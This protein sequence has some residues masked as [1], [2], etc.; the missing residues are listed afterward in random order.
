MRIKTYLF[1]CIFAFLV[2][3][4]PTTSSRVEPTY[5]IINCRIIP[6]TTPVIEKGTIIIR[7]GLIE[8]LGPSDKVTIPDD[9]EIIDTQ[10]LC[11][12][13]GLIDSHTEL[14]VEKPKEQPQRR[15]M[16]PGE[17]EKESGRYPDVQAFNLIKPNKSII[18]NYHQIGVTTVLVTPVKGIFMGQSVLLNLNG[19]EKESMVVKNSVALHV[20]F[21]T[22]RG[23]YPETVMGTMAFLRQSFLDA[24][25]YHMYKSLFAKLGKGLKRQEYNPFL[26]AL[27]PFALE[28]KPIAF[29]C[30]NQEDIKRTLRLAQE[31]KLTFLICGANEAWRVAGLLKEAQIP[32]LISVD[33][34]PPSTSLYINQGEEVK[35]KAEEEIYPANASLLHKAG[36]TFALT[37]YG[38]NKPD[39]FVSNIRQAI[40]SGLPKEEALKALTVYPSQFLG[41]S[42]LLG[43]LE[44]GKI[45]NIILTS[46]EIFEEKTFVKMVFVDGVQFMLKEPKKAKESAGL[47]VS[48]KWKGTVLSPMGD[49]ETTV[50]FL[51]EGSEIRGTILSDLGKWEITWGSLKGN[52]LDFSF[53]ANVMGE[54]IE[55]NFRGTVEKDEIAGTI[56]FEGGSARLRL[57]RIPEGAF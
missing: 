38:L 56:S 35:K 10:G 15:E 41:V 26:E 42:N 39:K 7:D 28:K 25:Y 14:F 33:F 16:A 34:Q 22:A 29:T 27:I 23:E 1:A 55:M 48:G 9:A 44:P 11:A 4:P 12:Y 52:E 20:R 40:K 36:I 47:D 3:V 49:L 50:E 43:S 5:A 51:Q 31:L 18:E 32:L 57:S 30:A 54:T 21:A 13:P 17:Q 19:E 46:G 6:V 45:A 53:T 8:A 24:E 37:S 2:T